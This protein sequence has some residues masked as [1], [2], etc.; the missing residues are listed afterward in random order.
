LSIINNTFDPSYLA[1]IVWIFFIS[2]GD[3]SR[4]LVN[5]EK[6]FDLSTTCHCHI[7]F[8]VDAWHRDHDDFLTNHG[9]LLLLGV[10]CRIILNLRLQFVFY[11][12]MNWAIIISYP[13]KTRRWNLW[14][15]DLEWEYV[16]SRQQ[17]CILKCC[18]N[19][20]KFEN[21]IHSFYSLRIIIWSASYYIISFFDAA[22]FDYN[23]FCW[24]RLV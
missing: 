15:L 18:W 24:V 3:W 11:S 17:N 23:V 10:Y 13:I 12:K 21:S 5:E 16:L 9:L 6:V 22:K 7:E 2:C 4:A 20:I 8:W 14:K 19:G 1:N